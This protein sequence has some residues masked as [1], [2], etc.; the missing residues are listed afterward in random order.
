MQN[1]KQKIKNYLLIQHTKKEFDRRQN[2]LPKSISWIQKKH[3]SNTVRTHCSVLVDALIN[4]DYGFGYRENKFI[5]DRIIK[6]SFEKGANLLLAN[7]KVKTI[8]PFLQL[9]SFI[10]YETLVNGIVE[11]KPK[12][13]ISYNITKELTHVQE[14]IDSEVSIEQI[15]EEKISA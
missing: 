10:M 3:L 4:Q 11:K 15:L 2:R 13:A 8:K 14:K 7:N 9:N 5:V 12:R 1:T 6:Y